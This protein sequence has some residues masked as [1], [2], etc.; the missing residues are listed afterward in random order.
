MF[1]KQNKNRFFLFRYLT[2]RRLLPSLRYAPCHLPPGGRLYNWCQFRGSEMG[3]LRLTPFREPARNG[4]S[5]VLQIEALYRTRRT[6]RK[7]RYYRSRYLLRVNTVRPYG[8]YS[9][10]SFADSYCHSEPPCGVKNLFER[11]E[12]LLR[13]VSFFV[14]PCG[15]KILRLR[16]G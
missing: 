4:Q 7:M 10:C 15:E 14:S 11:S 8:I 3:S 1:T 9:R 5:S 13:F 6:Q 12:K 16:S 2:T